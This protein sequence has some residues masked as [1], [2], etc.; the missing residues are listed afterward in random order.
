MKNLYDVNKCPARQKAIEI[1]E[2]IAD[3]LGKPTIF[4]CRHG[5]TRWYDVEDAITKII[6]GKK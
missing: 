3:Y 1:M 4:D 2:Y 6:A 5:D